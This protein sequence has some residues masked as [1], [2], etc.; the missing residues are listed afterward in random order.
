M[1]Y[2]SK[3]IVGDKRKKCVYCGK[4]FSARNSIIAEK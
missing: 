3:G 4:S 2:E 1:L